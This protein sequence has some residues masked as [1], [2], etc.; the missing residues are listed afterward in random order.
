MNFKNTFKAKTALSVFAFFVIHVM[1]NM[2]MAQ[3]FYNN[4]AQIYTSPSSVIQVNGGFQNNGGTTLVELEHHGTITI[5]NSATPGNLFLTNASVTKGNGTYLVEQDW[6]NDAI[7]IADNSTVELYGSTA[8]Q[9]IT[10]SNGTATTFNNLTL[11]G[12]GT[13]AARIK[14]MTVDATVS[15]DLV[16]NDRELATDNYTMFITNTA[17]NAVTNS[18]TFGSEGFVSSLGNGSLSWKVLKNTTYLY[19]TG[20]SLISSRYRP[21][22][23]TPD[24]HATFTVR[25]ANNDATLDGFNRTITDS[26][27]CITYPIYYHW[28]KRTDG[29]AYAD[30][31][32]SF[33]PATDGRWY[34]MANWYPNKW[35]GMSNTVADTIGALSAVKRPLWQSFLGSPNDPFILADVRPAI[36][37]VTGDQVFCSNNPVTTYTTSG[38]PNNTYSWTIIGGGTITSDPTR[39]TITVNWNNNT[40]GSISVV[41]KSITSGCSSA[42]S[43]SFNI[44]PKASPVA[45]FNT[46]TSGPLSQLVHFVSTSQGAT[47]LHWDFGNGNISTQQDP[48]QNFKNPGSYPVALVAY[49][50][51]GCQDT[52]YKDIVI[53]EGVFVPNVF[54]PNGDGVNDVFYIPHAGLKEFNFQV[55]NR[56]GTMIWETSVPEVRWD[57]RTAAGVMIPGGTYYYVLKAASETEDYSQKGFITVF[58]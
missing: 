53:T 7:F 25:M 4:G 12:T 21:V 45:S 6:V 13:A 22:E 44:A 39:Q 8:T 28:I 1:M 23:L 10:T 51:E 47:S 50:A 57:G 3:I 18:T 43:S 38:N 48:G 32:L 37:V 15:S 54:S 40:N 56:W 55:F 42:P 36:P 35:R 27:V 52:L 20:S 46:I 34:G 9:L 5:A 14:R 33:D 58:K 24:N 41:E 11:S 26:S 49:N 29:A 30:V 19:P 16:L 31:T 17:V 2:A